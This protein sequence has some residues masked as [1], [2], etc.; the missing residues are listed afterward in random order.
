MDGQ[1]KRTAIPFSG[2][3]YQNLVGLEL[4]CDWLDDPS[5]YQWVKFEA[6]DGQLAQGLDDIVALCHDNSFILLQIK[7]TVNFN[8]LTI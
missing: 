4:L 1:I 7:F 8:N 5:L 3:V 6:D 2:Y